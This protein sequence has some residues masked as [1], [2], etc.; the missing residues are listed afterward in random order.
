MIIY[1]KNK[2]TLK[3][4]D[5][6]FKC[7]I[8]KGGISKEKKEGDKKTPIGI[9]SIGNLYYRNDKHNKPITKLKCIPIRKEMGWCD[10]LNDK[11]NYNKL[12]STK[13]KTKHEKYVG[14]IHWNFSYSL[15]ILCT[16]F[17]IS[18]REKNY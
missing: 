14:C 17:L 3:I 2:H 9:Y 11:K 1:I 10:D 4:D 8:G 5:F 16:F 7:C 6:T 12:I 18:K 13:K 15:R